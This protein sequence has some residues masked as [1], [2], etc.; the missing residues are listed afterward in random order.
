[1]W[2]VT[3][4]SSMEHPSGNWNYAYAENEMGDV[5]DFWRDVKEARKAAG[6]PA[7]RSHKPRAE[8]VR[9]TAAHR[10]AGWIQHTD[11]HWQIRLSGGT[12]DYWPSKSKWM[13]EHKVKVG[14]F[15]DIEAFIATNPATAP[16]AMKRRVRQV[17]KASQT[18]QAYDAPDTFIDPP[19]TP[20]GWHPPCAQCG[21]GLFWR[22]KDSDPWTCNRCS[23]FTGRGLALNWLT[24][25]AWSA[26][27]ERL[28]Q[29]ARA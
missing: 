25:P 7:R 21:G 29:G 28:A 20:E 11:W 10:K 3:A 5:G 14:P 1:M 27:I 23:R 19:E 2:G 18:S 13:W 12:L 9:F 26:E 17:R 24:T 8:K 16:I 15:A 4:A 22:K 6:L